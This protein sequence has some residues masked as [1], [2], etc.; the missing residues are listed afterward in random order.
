MLILINKKVAN[1]IDAYVTILN[2]DINQLVLETYEKK[3]GVV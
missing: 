2:L 1:N 3:K